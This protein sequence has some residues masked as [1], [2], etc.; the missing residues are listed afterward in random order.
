[1]ETIGKCLAG[2]FLL[3]DGNKNDW[4]SFDQKYNNKLADY[5][6]LAV[7]NAKANKVPLHEA[8]ARQERTWQKWQTIR[9]QKKQYDD[10]PLFATA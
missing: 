8:V 7:A 4:P 5:V 3:A 6:C 10:L 1:M 2:H 9:E